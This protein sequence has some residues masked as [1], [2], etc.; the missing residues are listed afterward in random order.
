MQIEA[1]ARTNW[2]LNETD[3]REKIRFSNANKVINHSSG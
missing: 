1:K 3:V 2:H